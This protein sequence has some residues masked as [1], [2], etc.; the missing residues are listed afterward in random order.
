MIINGDVIWGALTVALPF[1]PMT[2]SMLWLAFSNFAD[3]LLADLI[4]HGKVYWCRRLLLLIFLLPAAA[5]ATP[6][7]MGFVLFAALAKLYNPLMDDGHEVKTFSALFRM[8]EVVGESYPQA[9]LGEYYSR[10]G[11]N[12][13]KNPKIGISKMQPKI[14]VMLVLG[15]PKHLELGLKLQN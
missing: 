8:A 14:L 6:I 5:L 13:H 12:P 2:I 11:Q 7:Y 9:L 1:L 3:K 10:G 4:G 15:I